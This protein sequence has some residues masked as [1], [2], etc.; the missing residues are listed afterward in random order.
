MSDALWPAE[1]L[2][3]PC[4]AMEPK[5]FQALARQIADGL[6]AAR[7][8]GPLA[9]LPRQRT[10]EVL[11]GTARIS[12]KGALMKSVP[13]YFDWL[14]VAATA[15]PDIEADLQEALED[16]HVSRILLDI[17]SPGGSSN[18]IKRVADAIFAA[19]RGK[20]PV[21]ARIE[22][23]AASAAYWIGSQATEISAAP[24]ALV[25][26]IGAYLAYMDM[27]SMASDLGLRVEVFSSG[28]LKGAGIPGTSLTQEQRTDLQ[29]F[30][31]D[32][33]AGFVADVARGRRTSPEKV[34]GWATGGIWSADAALQ[35]GLVD[36]VESETQMVARVA[37]ETSKKL[38]VE[39]PAGIGAPLAAQIVTGA[40]ESEGE[41]SMTEAELKAL[42]EKEA[43]DARAAERL[44]VSKI[45]ADY[46]QKYPK[47]AQKAVDEGWTLEQTKAAADAVDAQLAD[48]QKRRDEEAKS[49]RK[50]PAGAD[51]VPAG[52]KPAA[53]AKPAETFIEAAKACQHSRGYHQ[54]GRPVMSI[55]EAMSHIA[56]TKPELY[57]Q[58]LQASG[59]Q[60]VLD[61]RRRSDEE[62]GRA[63]TRR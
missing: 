56:R 6:K 25:G 4:W 10:L 19:A 27:S 60:V 29:K 5:A 23:L 53:E 20:K 45:T 12:V 15:Y 54:D 28:P 11:D 16:P 41:T 3:E 7:S 37:P 26:S 57:E 49:Q 34:R 14:G 22:D 52:G 62:A 35:M 36:R 61:G 38:S 39:K 1:L 63:R 9:A 24:M 30:V 55:G 33:T 31:D 2:Q 42:R 46:G 13:R 43:S 18:G 59:G 58:H 50:A 21:V 8:A 40:P 32:V 51:P 17:D 47:L 48:E 44:R